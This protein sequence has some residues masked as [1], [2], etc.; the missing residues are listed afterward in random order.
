MESS[1]TRGDRAS[2]PVGAHEVDLQDGLPWSLPRLWVE[3]ERRKLRLL[4]D[5]GDLSLFFSKEK[6]GE[7]YSFK[8]APTFKA[9]PERRDGP[10]C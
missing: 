8:V 9:C 3:F 10:A 5:S 7:I 2:N 4:V 6:L 1:S